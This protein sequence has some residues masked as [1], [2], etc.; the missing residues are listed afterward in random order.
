MTSFG[1][2]AEQSDFVQRNAR[3][4]EVLPRLTERSN[5]ILIR[6][7]TEPDQA[8]SVVFYLGRLVIEDFMEILLNCANG[9]GMAGLKLVRP[10]L[11]AT[12]TALY[13]TQH[14]EEAEAFLKYHLVH[15]RKTLKI[16]ESVGIDLSDRIPQTQQR[17]I[18]E[19]Y[20]LIRGRYRQV[21]CPECGSQLADM[22]WTKKDVI[23]MC[24]E[25]GLQEVSFALYF[26]TTLFIH[27]TPTRLT[28]RLQET[29]D[30]ITFKEGAQRSEADMAMVG[31]HACLALLL[32]YHNR[33]FDLNI[34]DLETEL[35]RDLQYA[36]T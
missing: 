14:P 12:V 15:Q 25:L 23:A 33:Y 29:T 32:E 2:P 28:S 7:L 31:A 13:L 30:G 27:T 17:E 1:I 26:Y 35:Q 19:Q 5:Q 3:F 36:W 9:Y 20:Q 6:T 34:A 10:M 24:R 4:M 22:S 16:A 11:E 8:H 21:T 18:E